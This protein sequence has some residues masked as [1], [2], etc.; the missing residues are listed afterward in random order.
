MPYNAPLQVHTMLFLTDLQ[1]VG[2]TC[3]LGPDMLGIHT[4]SLAARCRTAS[5]SGTLANGLPK[6]QATREYDHATIYA[7][8]FEWKEKLVNPSM[9]DN[10]VEAYETVCRLYLSGKLDDSHHGEEKGCH[11]FAPRG[12]I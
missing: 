6:I 10:K 11:G 4:L 8:S 7:L 1:R 9:A 3:D 5:N 12:I 2:S